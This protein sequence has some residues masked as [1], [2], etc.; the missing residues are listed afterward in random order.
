MRDIVKVKTEKSDRPVKMYTKEK[1][2]KLLEGKEYDLDESISSANIVKKDLDTS[3]STA[4]ITNTNLDNSIATAVTAKTNLNDIVAT[5][6]STKNSLDQS[7]ANGDFL[8]KT[9]TTSYTPNGDFNPATKKY[10]DD[11]IS[12]AGGGDMLK[13]VYDSNND[14]KVDSADSADSVEWDGV[15]NKP[16]KFPPTSHDHDSDYAP[17]IHNHDGTYEP[18]LPSKTGNA[19]K[20]LAVKGTED[21]TEWI[22][23]TENA[24]D[25]VN[26]KT[27]AVVLTTDEITDSSTNRYVSDSEKSVWNSKAD[28][29]NT[30][31]K[32]ETD[33][34]INEVVGAAP[35]A[36]DTLKEIA[37][38]LNNDDD[39]AGTMTTQLA[40][41]VDKVAGK[42]LSTEDY[43]TGE[44][45]KLAGIEAG[46]NK[47]VHPS[48]HPASLIVQDT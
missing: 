29:S 16:Q 26:G 35:Q 40:G 24:V 2:D 6:N 5:A 34:K 47:Y 7:I 42:Q 3:T 41:K 20:V 13:T 12:N 9:N 43:T 4:N 19:R 8:S 30:Y 48:T 25:S 10:V 46:S 17:K 37:E 33:N 39:F 36:L 45:S 23:Q 32:F 27:G 11:S 31:T 21:G 22:A 18:P 28:Q 1:I 14:G 15:N 38:S 44:K